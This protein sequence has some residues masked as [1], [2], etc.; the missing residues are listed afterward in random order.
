M[1]AVCQLDKLFRLFAKDLRNDRDGA[2]VELGQHILYLAQRPL[3]V[4]VG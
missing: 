1:Q 4:A 3:E 2:F